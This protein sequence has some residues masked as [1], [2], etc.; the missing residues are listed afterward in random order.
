L[1]GKPKLGFPLALFG[2]DRG[3][4]SADEWARFA[5]ALAVD[6][7]A[8]VEGA[9]EDA[10]DGEALP[11]FASSGERTV[12]RRSRAPTDRSPPASARADRQ[13]AGRAWRGQL[14]VDARDGWA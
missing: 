10:L 5:G 13:V 8:G 14:Q 7:L 3:H 2:D 9:A 1:F 6:P 11:A 12:R 4:G